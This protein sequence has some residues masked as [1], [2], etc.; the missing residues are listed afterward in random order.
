MLNKKNRQQL[1][2]EGFFVKEITFQAI[3]VISARFD[4][5]YFYDYFYIVQ[6]ATATSTVKAV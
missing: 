2:F 6:I 5:V 4:S 1:N 3:H